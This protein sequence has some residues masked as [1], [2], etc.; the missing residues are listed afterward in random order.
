MFTPMV[1]LLA[2]LL[3]GGSVVFLAAR[4]TPAG[5][6]D[7]DGC[8]FGV[9]PDRAEARHEVGDACL[10]T[11]QIQSQSAGAI[12]PALGVRQRNSDAALKGV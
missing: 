7:E 1:V 9:E 12:V 10:A 4:H 5:F 6:E 11:A 2:L 8:H 3:A